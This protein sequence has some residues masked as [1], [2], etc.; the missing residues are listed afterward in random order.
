MSSS[1]QIK[2]CNGCKQTSDVVFFNAQ[3]NKNCDEC[4]MS[5][6]WS[7]KPV[8]KQK[9]DEQ[10]DIDQR[11]P[12][13]SKI[14]AKFHDGEYYP[15]IVKS[16]SKGK[17]YILFNDGDEIKT[18]EKYIRSLHPSTVTVPVH[19]PVPV[20]APAPAPV[21]VQ[22]PIPTVTTPVSAQ[23]QMPVN[24]TSYTSTLFYNR[25]KCTFCDHF[26]ISGA[27]VPETNTV[28]KVCEAFKLWNDFK[29]IY[30]PIG[31]G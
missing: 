6:N 31:G 26:R 28:C 5:R 13:D 29:H 7:S 8:K 11:Y 1:S 25:K 21:H 15:G 24:F 30:R 4:I 12:N 22:I 18:K 14:E 16:F 23:L 17:Y 20:P 2:I 27:F 10:D 3:K 19:V 9:I